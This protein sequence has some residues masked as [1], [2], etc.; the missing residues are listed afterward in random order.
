MVGSL[1]A[2]ALLLAV[3]FI[4]ERLQDE[5]MLDLGLLRVPT[6]DGGLAAAWAISAALFAM[7]TYLTVYLQN[8]LGLSAVA[9]GVRFLPLTVAI[10]VAAGIAGRL[11]SRVSR[12]L[13]IAP[14]FLLIGA[15]LLLMRGLTPRSDWTH[16]LA[17]MI[18]SGIGG[19]LVSTPLISTAVGVGEPARAGMASGINATLRQ[20]GIATG[21]AALGTILVSHVHSSVLTGLQGTPLARHA[22]AIA[23]TVSTGGGDD[24]IASTPQPLR[25]L[26]ALTARS[27]LVDGLNTIMLI[28]AVVAFAAAVASFI[29]IRERDFVAL[30]EAEEEERELAVAA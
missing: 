17:G 10:F 9:T 30:E 18:V 22:H 27:A 12:R 16:L 4:L 11:I 14:G 25:G 15:G 7:F 2:S 3:F 1:A 29:L 28:S 21:V 26:V 20:V 6:F 19:G 23:H 13:L 8:S 24:A 5:P